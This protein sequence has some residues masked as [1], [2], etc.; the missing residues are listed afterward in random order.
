[1]KQSVAKF[2]DNVAC[3]CVHVY[4]CNSYFALSDVI[5]LLV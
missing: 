4:V 3:V 2:I 5:T 1:L